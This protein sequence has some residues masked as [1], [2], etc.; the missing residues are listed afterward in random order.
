MTRSL[1]QFVYVP[2]TTTY[3]YAYNNAIPQLPIT[4]A[5]ADTNWT[6]WAM[7][8]DGSS[9]R[10]YFFKGNT[11][12]TLYQFAFNPDTAA[13]EFGFNNAISELKLTGIPQDA[14]SDSF[15]MLHDGSTYRLYLR[16]LGH[17]NLLYQ[18]AF[19]PDTGC[20]EYGYDSAPV[21][22]VTGVPSTVDWSRWGMLHDGTNYRFY[23]MERGNNT[24]FFQAAYNFEVGEYQFGYDSIP[25]LSLVG[26]PAAANMADI[27]LLHDGLY[28]LYVQSNG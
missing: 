1:Y 20:Y 8:F 21:I 22:P 12:D 24:K 14:S 26:T 23:A 15:A 27:A 16:S 9:Y 3:Q 11:N 18:F 25:E 4:G 19:N 28:R 10:L 2:D 6:R 13:Y 17:A 7:L 5:P